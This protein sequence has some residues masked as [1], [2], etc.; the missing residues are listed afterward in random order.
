MKKILVMLSI[1]AM[2]FTTSVVYAGVASDKD[3]AS[4]ER[5]I[6]RSYKNDPRIEIVNET[7][8]IFHN[9]VKIE[10]RNNSKTANEQVTYVYDLKKS[11]LIKVARGSFEV[12]LPEG[13]YL[14]QS[15]KKITK[16]EYDIMI[17]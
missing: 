9:V 12:E 1:V 6:K 4:V 11:N 3:L 16:M 15:N 17:E 10:I 2:M 7:T 13:N 14:I 5:Q 8:V